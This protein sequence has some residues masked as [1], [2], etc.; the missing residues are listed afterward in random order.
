MLLY[1]I[2]P[3]LRTIIT[4]C[5]SEHRSLVN[6]VIHPVKLIRTGNTFHLWNTG[7]IERTLRV[8]ANQCIV[9]KCPLNALVVSQ[10]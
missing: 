7:Q 3:V 4:E 6:S 5:G 8:H 2:L 1:V 10:D 9:S